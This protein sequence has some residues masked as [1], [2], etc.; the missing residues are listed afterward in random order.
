M[1][2]FSLRITIALAMILGVLTSNVVISTSHADTS[3][4]VVVHV[5]SVYRTLAVEHLLLDGAE[6]TMVGTD[7]YG[8]FALV[9][10]P[11]SGMLNLSYM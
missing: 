4:E 8:S 2:T 6:Q 10:P 3:S 1:R 5:S 9:S 7:D 11:M